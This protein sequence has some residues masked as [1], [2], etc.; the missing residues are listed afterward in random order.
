MN[1]STRLYERLERIPQD[2]TDPE[3]LEDLIVCAFGAFERYYVCWKNRSG[4]Y[5]QDGHDLPDSLQDWLYPADGSTRDFE[6]LQV[7][8]GRGDDYFASDKNG[9]LEYKEPE[10]KKPEPPSDDMMDKPALRRSRT[11]SFIRP[12]S[13]PSSKTFPEP[14][15]RDSMAR[16]PS[17]PIVPVI[18]S[19]S[20]S[21]SNSRPTSDPV[22]NELESMLSQT[23]PTT[24]HPSTASRPGSRATR[25]SS[26]TSISTASSTPKDSPINSPVLSQSRPQTRARRPLSMS[27]STGLFPKIV[28]GKT[29]TPTSTT[30]HFP[31]DDYIPPIPPLPPL[32][33]K[34]AYTNAGIQ[35]DTLYP[36]PTPLPPQRPTYTYANASVQTDPLPSPPPRKP[37]YTTTTATQTTPLPSPIRPSLHLDTHHSA[38]STSSDAEYQYQYPT[39]ID[40]PPAAPNPVFMGRMLDYFNRPGYKL[41]DSLSSTYYHFDGV[42]EEGYG[43]GDGDGG[44]YEEEWRG[45]EGG[46]VV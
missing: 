45:V 34:S 15:Y 14:S 24:S 28:E 3:S 46:Q 19:R 35:N 12:L 36:E 29:L 31:E 32:P 22:M 16:P 7:V 11:V 37:V 43:Y 41:G 21:R 2:P 18:P 33:K 4:E 20:R 9:K 42:V 23:S 26:I 38:L 17:L 10:V 1:S 6:T 39:P 40:L 27:F 30:P 5:R 25:T 44:G 8:F 13:D